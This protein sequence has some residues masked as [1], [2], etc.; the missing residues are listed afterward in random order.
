MQN[1]NRECVEKMA[2]SNY[3]FVE[4]VSKNWPENFDNLNR[5][6]F[7]VSPHCFTFSRTE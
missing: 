7:F 1:Q 2:D 5:N 4:G 3:K 6:N